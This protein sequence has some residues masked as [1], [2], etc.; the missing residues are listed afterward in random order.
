[1]PDENIKSTVD[2]AMKVITKDL[3]KAVKENK[4]AVIGAALGYFLG[5]T[6]KN[7]EGIVTALV[8]GMIGHIADEKNKEVK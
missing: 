8:G 3:P 5:D 4:G 2:S 1:M 6:L 7:N